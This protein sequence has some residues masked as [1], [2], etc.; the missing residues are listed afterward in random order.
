MKRLTENT[1]KGVSTL[2]VGVEYKPDP[3]V[4]I[5]AGYNYQSPMYK[6]EAVRDQTLNSPGTW[7][8]STTDY[9]N[10][11]ATN[12][13]TLGLGFT[14]DKLRLDLGYQYTMRSG[15]FYPYMN[16]V[17]ATYASNDTGSVME[18]RND[19]HAVS[20]KDNRHQLLCS[21]T[22]SF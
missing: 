22:Y 4:A 12:R 17:S 18:L 19:C 15:N 11:E 10:W 9:T 20:V 6:K 21:L 2:K 8:A 16:G 13:L 5:R 7:M 1:L 3:S 14:F